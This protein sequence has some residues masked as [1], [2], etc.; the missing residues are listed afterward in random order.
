MAKVIGQDIPC[1]YYDR[2]TSFLTPSYDHTLSKYKKVVKP[3]CRGSPRLKTSLAQ[4]RVRQAFRDSAECWH[5]NKGEDGWVPYD[6]GYR[7]YWYWR[8]GGI[9]TRL[10]P[11]Q[12]FMHR[13]ISPMYRNQDI[14]W[15][16]NVDLLDTYISEAFPDDNFCRELS[17]IARFDYYGFG[18]RIHIH[19]GVEDAQKEFLNVFCFEGYVK[20]KGEVHL[21]CASSDSF[22]WGERLITYNNQPQEIQITDSPLFLGPRWYKLHVGPVPQSFILRLWPYEYEYWDYFCIAMFRSDEWPVL[23]EK[24]YFSFE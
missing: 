1:R 7:P 14:P 4:L 24:P 3:F 21:L 22:E 5:E 9:N 8:N 18:C 12:Y 16:E 6:D 10:Y 13:T 15:C 19:R 17:L 23:E 20:P 2:Y 11:Y